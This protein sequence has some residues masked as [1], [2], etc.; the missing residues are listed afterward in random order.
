MEVANLTSWCVMKKERVWF[1]WTNR[2]AFVRV[3]KD[4]K[5][6][7]DRAH[8]VGRVY[9]CVL[10]SIENELKP[11]AFDFHEMGERFY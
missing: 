2:Y 6:A 5:P 9:Y 11:H 8:K 1:P 4:T 7:L 3:N 10:Q